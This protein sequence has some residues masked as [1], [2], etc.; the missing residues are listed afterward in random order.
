MRAVLA[1]PDFRRLW[2]ART[3]SQWG[4][5][6][7]FVALAIQIY[8]LTGSGLGVAGVVVAE[9]IPLLLVAP[10]AG[11]VVDRLPRVQV[12]VAADVLRAALAGVLVI[13]HDDP[14]VIYAVAFGLSAGAALFNPAANSVLPAVVADPGIVAANSAVWTA[15]VLSQIILAP[16][17]GGLVDLAGPGWAFG[18]NAASFLVSARVLRGLRLVEPAREVGRRRLLSEAGEGVALV[19]GDRLLRALAIGQLLAALSAGA[20]SALLVVLAAEHLRAPA[21][22]YG[23]LLGAIGVGAALGP[24]LLLRLIPDPRRP[25]YVFGPY[26]LRGA[27]DLVLASVRSLPVAAAALAVYGVGSSTGAITFNSLL[28]SHVIDRTR[29]RVFALMDLLWQTGRL[30]SLGVG[31][32]LADAVGIR[33]VYYLGGALLLLAAA[34]GFAAGRAAGPAGRQG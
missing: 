8:R 5:I 34:V 6:F 12:M 19:R 9:I 7:S 2:T 31:G 18:L 25:L 32:L 13:W 21:D 22:A 11:V 1:Q 3:V 20:T 16:L 17:A 23:F 10:I 29:G 14:L 4:D 24:T 15:A 30:A 27:V 26:V 28:Q 33:A